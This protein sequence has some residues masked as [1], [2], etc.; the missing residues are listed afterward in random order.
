MGLLTV[1]TIRPALIT[2]L[3]M[4]CSPLAGQYRQ[5]ADNE[6]LLIGG[7]LFD[8]T[9]RQ[10]RPNPGIHIRNGRF[11]EIGA[12]ASSAA[13]ESAR[14][15]ELKPNQTLLPGMFDLHAH[16]NYDLVDAG[17]VEE[18]EFTGMLFLANGITATWSAGEYYPERVLTQRELIDS[19]AAVGPRLFASGPYMGA[20]RCEYSIKT[21]EDACIGWPNDISE[22]EIR[23]EVDYWASQGIIS[24]KIK[25]ATPEETRI[26]IDQAQKHGITTAGHLY[27][28]DY[29][30]DV[31]AREAIRM[32]LNRLEHN[33]TLSWDDSK[34][35]ELDEVIGLLLE[36]DVYFDANLQMYGGIDFRKKL[37]DMIWTDESRFF[38][39]YAR[40]LLSL[41]GPPLPESDPEDFNQRLAEL[42]QFYAAGGADLL[43][44]GTDEPVYTTLLAGFAYH[45]EL[46]ALVHAGIDPVDVLRAATI[47]GA[48]ALGVE[49]RLGSIE[50]GKL[51]DLFVVTGNPLKDIRLTRHVDL[52]IKDGYPHD[53]ETLKRQAEG[54]IGPAGPDEHDQW[55]LELRPLRSRAID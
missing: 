36:F 43:I 46:M 38:T 30:Y 39:P 11:V 25:Q 41:R 32:G 27:N 22:A 13:S 48:R 5:T 49:E 45:R 2:L 10:S 16:Y 47:N 9:G 33:M 29:E 17:R 6:L 42:R 34:S 7:R 4:M 18:V 50:T 26:L 24:L 19:G 23:E 35:A 44:V 8:A 28:Y 15:I 55:S 12:R 37:P 54:R 14:I 21:A 40:R 20:F 3:L 53:P 52:V 1:R 31:D 51:A